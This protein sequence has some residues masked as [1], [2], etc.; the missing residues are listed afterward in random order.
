MTLTGLCWVVLHSQALEIDLRSAGSSQG[1]ELMEGAQASWDHLILDACGSTAPLQAFSLCLGVY[2]DTGMEFQHALGGGPH[3]DLSVASMVSAVLQT[4]VPVTTATAPETDGAYTMCWGR[5]SQSTYVAL[6]PPS[7]GCGPGP[8]CWALHSVSSC[9]EAECGDYPGAPGYVL[10]GFGNASVT[11]TA[12]E[13]NSTIPAVGAYCTASGTE[14]STFAAGVDALWS[15]STSTTATTTTATATSTTTTTTATS[16]TTTTTATTTTATTT[17]ATTTTT[18]TTTAAAT[19]IPSTTSVA[20]TSTSSMSAA[21]EEEEDATPT[22]PPDADGTDEDPM[23]I[24]NRST[25]GYW[26]GLVFTWL[27]GTCAVALLTPALCALDGAG[28]AN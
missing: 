8:L 28:G 22:T 23:Y 15:T 26:V 2:V 24:R 16:T 19:V 17:T 14:G 5:T 11:A 20:A 7:A 18:T 6:S 13:G 1:W 10:S 21:T 27:A 4:S 12:V 9:H 3:A 25:S